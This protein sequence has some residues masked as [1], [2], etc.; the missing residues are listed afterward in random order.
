M[1]TIILSSFVLAALAGCAGSGTVPA[2]SAPS[3]SATAAP[4][5]A[6]A[7]GVATA[8]PPKLVAVLT[9]QIQQGGPESA[10]DVCQQKAPQMA[11]EASA[12]SGWQVRRVS[13]RPR[14]PKAAPDAWERETL[15]DFDRRAAVGA[16]PE[17]LER[18]AMVPNAQGAMEQRYMRALPTKEMC[19]S[20]HGTPDRL[21]PAVSEKLRS[22]YP[23]DQ[24]TGY[25]LGDIRG[26][27]TLRRP[28]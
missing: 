12:A 6:E 17:T 24:A 15:E 4:W 28:G 2:A 25:K 13:L 20:C 8:L 1:R 22:L 10:I 26:A 18:S 5:V 14:N 3:A 16:A 19:L 7:R 27:M 23:N 11:K 9:A 21:S